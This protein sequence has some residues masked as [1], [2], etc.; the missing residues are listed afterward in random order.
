VKVAVGSP[1]TKNHL[2]VA[3]VEKHKVYYKGEGDGFPQVRVMV[4]LVS[5][6]LHVVHPSTISAT[7]MH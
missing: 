7:T 1:E 6:R 4:N 3:P 5:L 2:N